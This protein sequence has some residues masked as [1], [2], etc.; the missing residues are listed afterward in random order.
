M[1]GH[2]I[3]EFRMN[4]SFQRRAGVRNTGTGNYV[5]LPLAWTE[6]AQIAQCKGHV[7][8]GKNEKKKIP[9][10]ACENVDISITNAL[11]IAQR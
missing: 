1:I 4:F 2:L 5:N 10:N 9:N 6:L 11:D 8:E 7:Q 3:L